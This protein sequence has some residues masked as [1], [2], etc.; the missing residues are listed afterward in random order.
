M[1]RDRVGIVGGGV[2]FRE[3]ITVNEDC[4]RKELC[5]VQCD[6]FLGP[7]IFTNRRPKSV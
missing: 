1:G 4:S 2:V 5:T 6:P 7:Q 3:E